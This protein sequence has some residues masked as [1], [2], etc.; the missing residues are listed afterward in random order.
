MPARASP[1]NIDRMR[2]IDLSS[3]LATSP[4]WRPPAAAPP[5]LKS[6]ERS[7]SR[8][9]ITG[10]NVCFGLWGVGRVLSAQC[11][12]T[13]LVIVVVSSII[14]VF[15]LLSHHNKLRKNEV[16][17]SYSTSDIDRW[18]RLPYLA[19]LFE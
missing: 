9:K 13:Q 6:P 11:T 4:T 1:Q 15:Y 17:L 2:C 7:S 3:L 19:N 14:I 5:V 16:T 12:E 8:T 10:L 18:P